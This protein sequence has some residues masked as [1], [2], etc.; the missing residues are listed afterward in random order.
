MYSIVDD[1]WLLRQRPGSDPAKLSDHV[2]EILGLI[3]DK[4]LV[5]GACT[6]GNTGDELVGIGVRMEMQPDW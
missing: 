3:V 4:A 1:T 2:A 6:K 5:T